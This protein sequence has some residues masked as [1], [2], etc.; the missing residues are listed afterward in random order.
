MKKSDLHETYSPDVRIN[1]GLRHDH[2]Y[3]YVTFVF[4]CKRAKNKSFASC[5]E[6]FMIVKMVAFYLTN[7]SGFGEILWV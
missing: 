3:L 5:R 2:L 6:E 1:N 4:R 7:V